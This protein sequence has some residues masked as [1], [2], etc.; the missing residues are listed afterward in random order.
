M[1]GF[2]NHSNLANSL[3]MTTNHRPALEGKRGKANAVRDSISHAR[4]LPQ[5]NTLKYRREAAV[6]HATAS[7]ALRDLERNL[8]ARD[9][10]Q[11]PK[12]RRIAEFETLDENVDSD[13]EETRKLLLEIEQLK[14]AA[15]P[16]FGSTTADKNVSV[17]IE[18]GEEVTTLSEKG[19]AAASDQAKEATPSTAGLLTSGGDSDEGKHA[20]LA[21]NIERDARENGSKREKS[22]SAESFQE[23]QPSVEYENLE[24]S[25][26]GSEDSESETKALLEELQKIKR[27]REA[28]KKEF[29]VASDSTKCEVEPSFSKNNWRSDS[30]FSNRRHH[31][32]PVSSESFTNDTLKS[33]FHK[34]FLKKYVR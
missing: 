4:A 30:V 13:D 27:E 28:T 23:K 32:A 3:I 20:G 7:G 9:N 5:Q 16:Q 11:D 19:E 8:S 22:S 33:E 10:N 18:K 24:E 1:A 6:D 14:E 29:E 12:R 25:D 21:H 2:T 31:T 26:Y 15:R 34:D 17:A